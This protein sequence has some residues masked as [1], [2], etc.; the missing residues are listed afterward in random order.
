MAQILR[1]PDAAAQQRYDLIVVGGGVYGVTLALES[2]RRGLR[3]LLLERDDFGGGVSWNSLRIIH[4]GLR[5]LQGLDLKRYFESVAERRWFMRHFPHQVRAMPCLMPLYGRGLKRP[6]VFR[7]A[8]ALNDLLSCRRNA[9]VPERTHLGRGR[10]VGAGRVAELFPRV[11]REGLVGGALWHDG[12]MVNSQRLLME[13]C[14]WACASGAMMLNYMTAIALE[15]EGGRVT[16][17]V[18]RDVV[19]DTEHV[20]RAPVVVNAAGPWCAEVAHAFGTQTEDMFKPSLAFNLLLDREPLGPTAVAVTPNYEG[21]RTYFVHNEREMMLA[22]TYHAACDASGEPVK[23]IEE[24]VS[25]FIDDLNQAVPGLHLTD[26]DVVRVYAGQLPAEHTGAEDASHRP[27]WV[28]HTRHGGP[29]GMVSVS[30]V[31]YTTARR[32]AE[33][34]L[35]RIPWLD[36]RPTAAAH[37]AP[38]EPVTGA[39]LEAQALETEVSGS[40]VAA[41][42]Q[43]IADEAVTRLDDLLLRRTAWALDPRSGEPLARSLGPRLGYDS[44]AVEACI[45][46]LY[47]GSPL[48]RPATACALEAQPQ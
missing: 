47:L 44:S 27:A 1:Q 15:A 36:N 29:A 18:A 14:R 3:P 46:A 30:G 41:A 21:A 9:D 11:D 45:D 31:K 4:G 23:P 42:E 38:P 48:P 13:M 25:S 35:K 20:Y 6:G 19:G 40:L 26:N 37:S 16:G 39:A 8:L 32:V 34:T 10:V 12:Q 43:L 2:A 22:G 33:Q 7:V 5:Y 24:L 17:V 28:D